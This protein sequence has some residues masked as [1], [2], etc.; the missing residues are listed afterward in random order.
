MQI[1]ITTTFLLCFL[2]AFAQE[3][4][5]TLNQYNEKHKKTGY[6]VCYLDYDFNLTT[7][8]KFPGYYGYE[9]YDNGKNTVKNFYKAKWRRAYQI[10]YKPNHPITDSTA[11]NL[12]DGTVTY[13]NRDTVYHVEVYKNGIP[14]TRKQ[15][16]EYDYYRDSIKIE[17][18]K[19]LYYDSIYNNNR[20][21]LLI[22]NYERGKPFSKEYFP[23]PN[24]K[25]E[26]TYLFP[27]TEFGP[28]HFPRVGYYYQRK[29]FLELGYSFRNTKGIIDSN[30]TKHFEDDKF[31]GFSI[32]ALGNFGKSESYFG[33]KAVFTYNFLY[34][35]ATEVGIINY[36]NF[37]FTQNDTRATLGAGIS[38]GG[39]LSIMYHYS[40]PL[41][42]SH[43]SNISRHSIGIVLF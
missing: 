30:R 36:T 37:D 8:E 2:A 28:L 6:W 40:I 25:S 15:F 39:F 5:D 24:R 14:V 32:S 38:V 11:I 29:S 12:I 3:S 20:E 41:A 16:M 21:T 10:T 1:R 17:P 42:D 9:Y 35:F 27:H 43:F 31:S 19:I 18:H 34:A 33:Q 22:Y 7:F 4:T 23:K 26:P 13:S